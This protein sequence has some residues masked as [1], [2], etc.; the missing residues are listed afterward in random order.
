MSRLRSLLGLA[1]SQPPVTSRAG[2]RFE[3]EHRRCN[4]PALVPWPGVYGVTADGF[5]DKSCLLNWVED[6]SADGGYW[7]R[8]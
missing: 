8:A 7:E 5:L 3:G 6:D 2:E 4:E 1:P